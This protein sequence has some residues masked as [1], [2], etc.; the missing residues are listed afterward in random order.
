MLHW[1]HDG[2]GHVTLGWAERSTAL[3]SRHVERAMIVAPKRALR[4]Q[5]PLPGVVRT[6]TQETS[7]SCQQVFFDSVEEIVGLLAAIRR[8]LRLASQRQTSA[9]D[10]TA[11]ERRLGMM[12][13]EPVAGRLIAH[14]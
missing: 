6:S 9:V 13:S 2:F 10:E 3:T 7:K 12:R 8:F 1:Y 4:V 14:Q 11:V 5:S